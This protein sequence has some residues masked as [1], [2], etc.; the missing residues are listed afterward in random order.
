MTT[1]ASTA[2]PAAH[3]ITVSFSWTAA[4]VAFGLHGVGTVVSG[5]IS[6]LLDNTNNQTTGLT[7]TLDTPDHI[8]GWA[9]ATD[10][11]SVG[12]D[13]AGGILT[14]GSAEFTVGGDGIRFGNGSAGEFTPDLFVSSITPHYDI[15]DESGV[16]TYVTQGTSTP[17]PASIALVGLGL[18]GLATLRRRRTV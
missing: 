12:F 17:E 18:A 11:Y 9:F 5:T 16:I 2:P 3:A 7:I 8:T 15:R 14:G 1:V 6:G 4:T 10:I 13:V